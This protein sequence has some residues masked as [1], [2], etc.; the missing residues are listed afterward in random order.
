M[1][2][3]NGFAVR[4]SVSVFVRREAV[5]AESAKTLQGGAVRVRIMDGRLRRFPWPTDRLPRDGHDAEADVIV[6]PL[7]L[8]PL[9]ER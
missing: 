9:S 8:E 2:S 4:F 5:A 3:W 1:A 7:R 6:P